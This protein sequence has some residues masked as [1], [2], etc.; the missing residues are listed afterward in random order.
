MS[1]SPS[2]TDNLNRV[3]AHRLRC[4]FPLVFHRSNPT[5]QCPPLEQMLPNAALGWFILH[6]VCSHR[7]YP[8]CCY[9]SPLHTRKQTGE[10]KTPGQGI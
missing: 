9:S 4:A 7:N 1:S 5:S 3:T 6:C 10:P 2:C 8:R